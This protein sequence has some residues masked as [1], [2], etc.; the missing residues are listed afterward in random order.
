MIQFLK[1]I[2][3]VLGFLIKSLKI[4]L[5]QGGF[6]IQFPKLMNNWELGYTLFG[7]YELNERKLIKKYI[8]P[9]DSVLELGACIGVV[10]LT[11]NEILSDKTKQVSV[12]PNPEMHKYLLNN[13]TQNGGLFY[14][15]SCI[16][17]SSP[18]VEFFSGGK[19][20]LSSSTLK[21]DGIK[22]IV[23]GK[24]LDQLAKQYFLFTALVMDI[25]GGELEFLRTF[26]LT[27]TNIRLIIW[28]TH[29]NMDIITTEE[30]AECYDLL[31]DYGFM[32][33]E[34]IRNVEAWIKG[35]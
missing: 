7:K 20:F 22:I 11:I 12:E 28:E 15:E 31:T 26:N 29:A 3:S 34:R 6:K 23:Q 16:V 18:Q 10:S 5:K 9:D 1:P 21:T 25:E 35:S 2:L 13:R 24:T 19:A 30:L 33:K 17:S 14:T 27:H 4:P 32:F 8:R